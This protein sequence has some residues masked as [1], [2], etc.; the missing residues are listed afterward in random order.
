MHTACKELSLKIFNRVKLKVCYSLATHWQE[1]QEH[2]YK[3][4][5]L[6]IRHVLTQ[7]L[8]SSVTIG[9]DK[10]NGCSLALWST[11][12]IANLKRSGHA[13]ILIW[14]NRHWI[15]LIANQ[16]LTAVKTIMPLVNKTQAN[17]HCQYFTIPQWVLSFSTFSALLQCTPIF[18][19]S[20]CEWATWWIVVAIRRILKN[21]VTQF[22]STT[23]LMA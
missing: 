15:Q 8:C 12:L 16:E 4:T 21:I 9:T 6:Q 18:N 7:V 22:L 1:D 17:S 14:M 10:S 23:T 3:P 19:K 20:V 2:E 13:F 11:K 5:V